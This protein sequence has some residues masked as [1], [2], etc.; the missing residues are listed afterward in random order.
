MK[1]LP[2]LLK[3]TLGNTQSR[4]QRDFQCMKI[5]LAQ[6]DLIIPKS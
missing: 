3:R 4:T 2:R 1:I 5:A 6:A